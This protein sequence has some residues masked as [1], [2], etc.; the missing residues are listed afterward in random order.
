MRQVINESILRF[1]LVITYFLLFGVIVIF[2]KLFRKELI[3]K[4]FD[5][6]LPSYWN[7]R[8]NI[9]PYKYFSNH[10]SFASQTNYKLFSNLFAK[11]QKTKPN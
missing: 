10:G 1:S 5:S 9:N 2:L 8:N 11:K 7:Q 3:A 6:D 4:N